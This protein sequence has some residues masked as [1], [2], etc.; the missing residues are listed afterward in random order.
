Q[1]TLVTNPFLQGTAA[2]Q[3]HGDDR[4]TVDLL[5]AEDIDAVWMIDRRRQPPLAKEAL[6]GSGGIERMAQNFQ[7]Q[8]AAGGM[9][10]R[11]EDG[12]HAP[13]AESTHQVIPAKFLA[14]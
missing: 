3:L 13:L 14:S 11:L 5:G 1:R 4:G 2:H 7:R 8:A 6:P 9:F 12:P 10:F